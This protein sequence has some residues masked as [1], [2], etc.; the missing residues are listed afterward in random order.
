M[1]I[2]RR[3]FV[4]GGAMGAALI[5]SGCAGMGQSLSLTEAIRRLLTISSQNAFAML[6]QSNGF[7][8][9]SL[10]R[11]DLPP[12]LGGAGA[13]GLVASLLRTTAVK[14]RLLLQA[15]RAAEKGAELAA[16][17]VAERIRTMSVEDA[18]SI[19][20]GGPHAATDLLQRDLGSALFTAMIPGADAGLRLFDSEVV[21]Q[22]LKAVTGYDI[23]AFGRDIAERATNSI[24]AAIGAE[25][26]RLRANPSAT[27]DPMLMAVL[28]LGK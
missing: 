10:T 9:N 24:Y 19:I 3:Q 22:A 27:N 20:R 16:P 12:Q 18:A 13:S 15:N 7:Y 21:A 25:E 28:S 8:D 23:A 17:I 1:T 11:I 14:D 26:A 2:S 4:G 5:L 6:L